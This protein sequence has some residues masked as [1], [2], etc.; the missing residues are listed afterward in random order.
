MIAERKRQ[1]KTLEQ[2]EVFLVDVMERTCDLADGS[3]ARRGEGGS[4]MHR[5]VTSEKQKN[6]RCSGEG[7]EGAKK[8][9]QLSRHFAPRMRPIWP[10]AA[11]P[12]M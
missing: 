4:V 8:H 9:G 10:R 5:G 1:D 7:E 2:L 6:P 3:C 12:C 11:D